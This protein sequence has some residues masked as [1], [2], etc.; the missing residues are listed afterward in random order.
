MKEE[1]IGKVKMN[2]E[3]GTDWE[4]L[5]NMS[6]EEIHAAALYDPDAQPTNE[7][8]WKNAKL[9]FPEAK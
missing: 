7:T 3:G 6:D 2:F 5:R 1:L 9:V 8:F 4:K